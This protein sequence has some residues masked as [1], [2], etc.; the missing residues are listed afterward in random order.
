MIKLKTME[1][2]KA[3][4]AVVLFVASLLFAFNGRGTRTTPGKLIF[5]SGAITPV[6]LQ[7]STYIHPVIM[8]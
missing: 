1:K 3:L 6:Q 4:I 2:A 5:T 7:D 8:P